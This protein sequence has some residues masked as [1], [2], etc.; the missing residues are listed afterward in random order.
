MESLSGIGVQVSGILRQLF[1]WPVLAM[2]GGSF[3]PTS[4]GING[5]CFNADASGGVNAVTDQPLLG[6]RQ[7]ITDIRF[8]SN[9]QLTMQFY[10]MGNGAILFTEYVTANSGGQIT[11]RGKVK[12]STAYN[13]SNQVG[14]G[15]QTNASGSDVAVTVAYYS[16]P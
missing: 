10:D 6:Q 9:T 7:V 12:L 2:D 8:S 13:G 1:S 11:L 3:Y 14:L 5:A 4:V 15:V 16:E